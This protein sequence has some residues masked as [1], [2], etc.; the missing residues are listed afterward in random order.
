[1]IEGI[2]TVVVGGGQAGLAMSYHLQRLG[3][4]HVVL[5]R[6]RVAQ[7]WRSERWDSLMFQFPNWSIQLPGYNYETDDPDGYVPKNEIVHFIEKYAALI[8]APLRCGLRVVALRQDSASSRL[9]IETEQGTHPRSELR[10]AGRRR[11]RRG[12][13]CRPHR[14]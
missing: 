2:D 12:F 8:D 13:H 7:S 1:V 6:G 5:E 3:R 14:R 11:Q 4:E 10:T 9:M